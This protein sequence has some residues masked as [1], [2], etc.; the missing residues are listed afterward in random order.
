MSTKISRREMLT[1]SLASAGLLAGHRVPGRAAEPE[2]KRPP[3]ADRS[4]DAPSLP[5]AVKRC[6]SYE[7]R[8]L[9]QTIDEAVD[10]IGGIRKLVV[11][12]TVTIKLNVTGG[13]TNGD[14]GGLPAYRTYHVHPNMVAA[15]CAAIHDAGAK[16]IIVV[17]SQF[18]AK[19]PEEDLIAGGWDVK[20][21]KSAGGN[22]VTFEDTRN[23]GRWPK[24]SRLN[25]PWGGFL[26]PAFDLNQ[27]Y[28]KTD[29]FVS[30]AKMKDHGNTG[31]TLAVKNL[32]GNMP[33][34]LYGA[35][36]PNE[37]STSYR[38]PIVHLGRKA[39]PDGVPAEIGPDVPT[40][41]KLRVPRATADCL[42]ARPVDLAIIDGIET[43]R[44][45]EGFWI[46]GAEPIQPKLLMVGRNAVCTDAVCTAVM[47]Y[48]PTAGFQQFPF[49]GENHL[50]MLASVAVGTNDP[51]R[52]EVAGLSIQEALHPFNPKRLS[53]PLPRT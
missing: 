31:V 29:V 24:Y 16:R 36:A 13:P 10:L 25:V 12:K 28:E 37:S 33:S 26:Y 47:G 32:F 51:K 45:G 22:Q 15:V 48:D 5:V 40:D 8:L 19:P 41:W 21:I 43:N 46:R 39:V 20:A 3:R 1:C 34:S 42:G 2:P 53:V 6:E 23:R 44:G 14:L 4:G 17:E 18:S 35:D 27:R 7:P 50:Q 30:L 49:Q 11:N 9:R 38:G 52:I